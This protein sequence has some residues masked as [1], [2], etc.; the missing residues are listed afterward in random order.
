[1]H[2]FNFYYTVCFANHTSLL[3]KNK[4]IYTPC[5]NRSVGRKKLFI[6]F[7]KK[8]TLFSHIQ[9]DKIFRVSR[10]YPHSN[11]VNRESHNSKP[12]RP[13]TKCTYCL[14]LPYQQNASLYFTYT[15]CCYISSQYLRF[16]MHFPCCV[17]LPI[18]SLLTPN[19]VCSR[20]LFK[21]HWLKFSQE[22][23]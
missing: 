20:Y 8:L 7:K 17:S 19:Y 23:V 11:C 1:M 14:L 22:C 15:I 16:I 4:I 10:E 3:N 13:R 21:S 18:L 12:H 2:F 9:E 5:W 6:I